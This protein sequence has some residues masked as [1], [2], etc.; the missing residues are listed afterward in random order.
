MRAR[1]SSLSSGDIRSSASSDRIQG[2]AALEFAKFFWSAKFVHV[3]SKT[4][5]VYLFARRTV[6]S[7]LPPSTTMISEAT[8]WT[9]FRAASSRFYSLS[10]MRTTEISTRKS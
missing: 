10:A 3:L 6:P 2:R 9:L 5:S 7:V 4:R 8:P 1:I